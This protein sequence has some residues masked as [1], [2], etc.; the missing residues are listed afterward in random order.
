MPSRT[1]YSFAPSSSSSASSSASSS[2]VPLSNLG[3]H[4]RELFNSSFSSNGANATAVAGGGLGDPSSLGALGGSSSRDEFEQVSYTPIYPS[5]SSSFSNSSLELHESLLLA[6]RERQ[7]QQ[8]LQLQLQQQQQQQQP[9][10][11]HQQQQPRSGSA[12][13]PSALAPFDSGS[14]PFQDY[15]TPNETVEDQQDGQTRPPHDQV[16]TPTISELDAA[17]PPPPIFPLIRAADSTDRHESSHELLTE[18]QAQPAPQS[19]RAPPS[20]LSP[21]SGSLGLTRPPFLQGIRHLPLNGFLVPDQAPGQGLE[22][23][24]GQL[25]INNPREHEPTTDP[26]QLLLAQPLTIDDDLTELSGMSS[27]PP[28]PLP[29]PSPLSLDPEIDSESHY[30]YFHRDQ[31]AYFDQSW[32]EDRRSLAN[33]PRLPEQQVLDVQAGP[34]V[35][36]SHVAH[37]RSLASLQ[38]SLAETSYNETSSRAQEAAPQAYESEV[39]GNDRSAESQHTAIPR[40]TQ[41]IPDTMYSL[42]DGVLSVLTMVSAPRSALPRRR[43]TTRDYSSGSVSSDDWLN[44]PDVVALNNAGTSTADRTF[45]DNESVPARDE[46][47][48]SL[49]N[50]ENIPPQF[51]HTLA[52]AVENTPDNS[53]AGLGVGAAVGSSLSALETPRAFREPSSQSQAL[54]QHQGTTFEEESLQQQQQEQP[55]RQQEQEEMRQAMESLSVDSLSIIAAEAIIST[56]LSDVASRNVEQESLM[57]NTQADDGRASQQLQEEPAQ[58]SDAAHP[59]RL[60][61]LGPLLSSAHPGPAS[62]SEGS[63]DFSLLG[64][65]RQSFD[66]SILSMASRIRQARLARLL[67]LMGEQDTPVGY[68]ERQQWNRSLPLDTRSMV[69]HAS[70]SRGTSRAGSLEDG[71]LDLGP[72]TDPNDIVGPEDGRLNTR[73]R[74]PVQPASFNPLQHPT[75][76]EVL[77]SNGNP[78]DG[79]SSESYASSSTSSVASYET[80]EERDEDLEWMDAVERRRRQRAQTDRPW[81]NRSFIRGHGRPRVLST[82]TVFEGAEHVSETDSLL[83]DNYRYHSL[84]ASWMTNPNGESWSDDDG[85]DPQRTNSQRHVDVD[86]KDPETVLMRRGQVSLGVLQPSLQHYYYPHGTYGG[87]AGPGLGPE[88]GSAGQGGLYYIYGNVRNRFGADSA[89]RRRV[90]SEM[91]DLLRREQEWERELAMYSRE[92]SNSRYGGDGITAPE[93]V[94]SGNT[95]ALGSDP[96]LGTAAVVTVESSIHEDFASEIRNPPE[97]DAPQSTEVF[98]EYEQGHSHYQGESSTGDAGR[99]LPGIHFPSL[100]P[101]ITPVNRTSPLL[102]AQPSLNEPTSRRPIRRAQNT[103]MIPMLRLRTT[104]QQRQRNSSGSGRDQEHTYR[105]ASTTFVP[106]PSQQQQQNHHNHTMVPTSQRISN[107]NAAPLSRGNRSS[108]RTSHDSNGFQHFNLAASRTFAVPSAPSSAGGMTASES[109]LSSAPPDSG[110]ASRGSAFRSTPAAAALTT[111]MTTI[112]TATTSTRAATAAATIVSAISGLDHSAGE[113]S[114]LSSLSDSSSMATSSITNH[115]PSSNSTASSS[116]VNGVS[117]SFATSPVSSATSRSSSSSSSLNGTDRRQYPQYSSQ[118]LHPPHSAQHQPQQH[119]HHHHHHHHHPRQFQ[120][121]TRARASNSLYV[122]FEGGTLRPEERWRRGD[123]E[124][125]GR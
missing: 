109:L 71:L 44:H 6:I 65:T 95:S 21:P 35:T 49:D 77:D 69:N 80:I 103:H 102:V 50:Q 110:A 68:T 116:T 115:P 41:T 2:F 104:E 61:L 22:T 112:A 54:R 43:Y 46:T 56:A 81:R 86:D 91:T 79:S 32:R 24:L 19:N 63:L 39:T 53:G 14:E 38:D 82:G 31:G 117:S 62:T 9:Q 76:A 122:N 121:R 17:M 11:P 72:E 37:S 33:G 45:R 96:T 118:H 59:D 57:S 23:E 5:Y 108:F 8:L 73:S 18:S 90:L 66:S 55:Q 4:N 20:W 97:D 67:R 1:P 78:I 83:A 3:L 42:A 101:S 105:Y 40:I 74:D 48:I 106:P 124:M 10:Q 64:S 70:G 111:T 15:Q 125:I 113:G 12:T 93:Q 87:G 84:K 92:V 13:P 36:G 123:E 75:F 58:L 85:D 60:G 114:R 7:Q 52:P 88:M 16:A 27:V 51:P 98:R 29:P 100:E 26:G 94:A 47:D 119:Q 89:R 34:Y 107:N 30:A 99:L 28:R 120:W 25:V